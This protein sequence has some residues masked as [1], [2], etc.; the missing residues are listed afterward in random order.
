MPDDRLD[1]ST[2]E[3]RLREGRYT[4]TDATLHRLSRSVR[5]ERKPLARADFWR[6]R[7]ALVVTLAFGIGLSSTGGALAVSGI[8]G[9]Q[10]AAKS[11]YGHGCPYGQKKNPKG[12]CVPN[13][14]KGK[15]KGNKHC[16]NALGWGK[17]HR[18]HRGGY[19]GGKWGWGG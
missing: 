10:D 11:Q 17:S 5:P 18:H 4:P 14:D 3:E 16:G 9:S 7:L 6:S 15:K 19:R 13:C 1:P 8:S 2:I 12:K